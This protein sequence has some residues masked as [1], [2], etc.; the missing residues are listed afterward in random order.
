[1][2][3]KNF[4][5]ST[6]STGSI[7]AIKDTDLTTVTTGS[8]NFNDLDYNSIISTSPVLA[9]Q[10]YYCS[11]IDTNLLPYSLEEVF[12]KIKSVF[13]SYGFELKYTPSS[14]LNNGSSLEKEVSESILGWVAVGFLTTGSYFSSFPFWIR[15]ATNTN[16][17]SIT[18]TVK[19]DSYFENFSVKIL[20]NDNLLV[21]I[22][23]TSGIVHIIQEMLLENL[24]KAVDEI[25]NSLE[26]KCYSLSEDRYTFTSYDNDMDSAI[27]VNNFGSVV[28]SATSAVIN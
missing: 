3:D 13:D 20:F 4:I 17:D 19:D 2:E 23:S 9:N 27:S 16:M 12:S 25:I 21:L 24:Q 6:L 1:M 11:T 14:D 8:F 28:S 22:D 15:N 5:T 10:Y 26:P 7:T 18:L